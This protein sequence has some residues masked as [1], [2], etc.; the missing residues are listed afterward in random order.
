MRV[1]SCVSKSMPLPNLSE[2]EAKWS[3]TESQQKAE[4]L[5][6]KPNEKGQ[7]RKQPK[8]CY[9]FAA[10]LLLLLPASSGA[11]FAGLL[12]QAVFDLTHL[13]AHRHKHT[14]TEAYIP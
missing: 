14:H 10:G 4:Q 6:L 7:E 12:A 5:K 11:K 3:Q 9:Y 13:Q 2:W 1:V 8:P